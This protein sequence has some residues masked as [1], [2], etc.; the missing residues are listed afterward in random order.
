MNFKHKDLS[1]GRWQ[2]LSLLEQLANIGSEV[3]R[4]LRWLDKDEKFYQGA[5]E[6]TLELFDLTLADSRWKGRLREIGRA[7]EIFCDA[8]TGGK[9]YNSSL[10]DIDRYFFHYALYTR[11]NY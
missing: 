2:K 8:I 9:E 6:R 5:V 7:R 4:A 11:R 1:S 10:K 3:N